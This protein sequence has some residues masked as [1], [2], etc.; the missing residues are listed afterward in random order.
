MFL[1]CTDLF[2][3]HGGL[4]LNPESEQVFAE[5]W[6]VHEHVGGESCSILQQELGNVLI[7]CNAK[8]TRLRP[9]F[10]FIYT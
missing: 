2:S 8:H 10:L 4:L 5:G 6:M 9:V 1:W 3:V 7:T